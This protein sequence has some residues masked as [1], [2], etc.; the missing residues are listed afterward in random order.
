MILGYT[1]DLI[2]RLNM[3]GVFKLAMSHT[4]SF[5]IPEAQVSNW[6]GIKSDKV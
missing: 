3:N 5:T 2:F 6:N 4:A 1:F